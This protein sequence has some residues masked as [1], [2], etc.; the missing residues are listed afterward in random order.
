[1]NT[2][3]DLIILISITLFAAVVNGGLGHGF[4]SITVPVALLFYTNRILNP[5]LVL[6]EIF[7]N[8]YILLTNWRGVSKVWKRVIPILI[9]MVPGIVLGSYVLSYVHPG[10]IKFTTFAVLLP[11]ILLQAAGVR[12]PINS[13]RV[14]GLPFG[15]G[16][17]F[18]YSITTVSGP[19]LALMF[20]NQGFV[21][22][23]FR[24]ALGLIRVSEALLT[25]ST[26]YL[27]GLYSVQSGAIFVSIAPSVLI[28]VPLGAYVIHRINPETFRR[29]CMS[30]DAWVVGF[31]LSRVLI[32]LDLVSSPSAYLLWLFV[33]AADSYLLYQFFAK[34][35]LYQSQKV[36]TV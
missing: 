23:E 9:G 4:S 35:K 36:K 3:S 7:I 19:P 1:M 5:A 25:A 26:Y 16:V 11:L 29:L 18:L 13:E 2:Q 17:G 6:V 10:W 30:F 31:G 8:S 33:I 22:E 32:E 14:V 28:G 24:A 34:G 20:N 15:T 27:L 12:K 21:K